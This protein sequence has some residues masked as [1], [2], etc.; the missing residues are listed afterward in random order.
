ML[1]SGGEATQVVIRGL[2][3][4]FSVITI[5]G[6]PIPS[7][8]GVH[9]NEGVDP[10][11]HAPGGKEGGNTES[12]GR[13]TDIGMVSSNMLS[14]IEVYKTVTPDMDAAAIGGTVNLGIRKAQ[15][16]PSEILPFA[17]HM[18]NITFLAQG[19]YKDILKSYNP[20][21]FDLTLERRLFNNKFGV[22]M[23]GIAQQQ[24]LTSNSL[25]ARY[26]QID[27][28]TDPDNLRLEGMDL[29]F[30]PRMEKRYN[31]SV[32]LDYVLPEG[33][34]ALL[35]IFSKS[36]RNTQY[37]Q[38]HYGLE[39]GGNQIDYYAS[40]M[41]NNINLITNILSY[42]QR[43][44]SFD[45][46]ARLSHSYSENISP[47][48]WRMQFAQF[49]AGTFAI[50]EQLPPVEIA[51]EAF[52]LVNLDTMR[53][54]NVRTSNSLTSQRNMR[55]SLDLSRD[56]NIADFLSFNLKAGGMYGYTDRS[57]DYDEGDGFV[58]F[59]T[60]G[61]SILNRL[62]WLA[63][64]GTTPTNNYVHIT[65]FL[66]PDY[67]IGTYLE[68]DYS[69]DNSLYMDD[70]SIIKDVVVDYGESLETAPT[71][72]AGTWVP[73]VLGN[74]RS[75]YSGYEYRSAGYF[76]GTFN[77]GNLVTVIAGARY[78]NLTTK[79]RANRYYNCTAANP[80]PNELPHI[81]TTIT[82][83]HGY[84]LPDVLVRLKPLSWLGLR[85][86]YTNTISYPGFNE[87]IPIIGVYENSVNWNNTD[88]KPALSG[89]FDAQLSIHQN[90][91]GLFAIGGF[92]KR[93]NDF[94][95]SQS[96]FII[97]P[98]DYPG[99]QYR[100]L[101]V[102]GYHINTYYNNPKRVDVYGVEAEWQTHFWY[103][104]K[105]L[106]GL[107]LN[108]N[109]THILS[110]ATYPFSVVS[111]G[112]FPLYQPVYIDSTYEDRLIDQPDD[113]INLSLGYDY[114]DFSILVSMIY[115]S[116]IF[117]QTDFWNALR[118]DKAEYLRWDLVAN[119]KLPWYN[120]EVFL[121]LNNLNGEPDTYIIRGNGYPQ[122]KYYYGLTVDLGIR[123]KL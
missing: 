100:E 64:Y 66:D 11:L 72:G 2:Q 89:N 67:N 120:S 36:E 117:N 58:R 3:P 49:A 52:Q 76:M 13:G 14:S 19:G 6:V 80:Y 81:D 30:Y 86:A 28:A 4:R 22:L 51:S 93:I 111:P 94:V 73:S 113:I 87:I 39:N 68:N 122:S 98:A 96:G 10:W 107:V 35:N 90:Y 59:G 119:Q 112:V 101:D 102:S 45:V 31:G 118:V 23:Q 44:F 60:I 110:E 25:R 106:N 47:D 61:Q 82:K 95:F 70:L 77:F 53:L 37:F 41:P 33:N 105:P 74:G 109:F 63:D 34:I 69:F 78:Q 62:P 92:L 108:V 42:N 115:Q 116:G 40:N 50:N 91:I 75:D 5:D 21:K 99:L 123:L 79:Y 27:K 57:Y 29:F 55:A 56:F 15:Y 8:V 114:K 85:V 84:W 17:S 97:D 46:D 12:G 71:G 9:S 7:N 83:T 103:L 65:P 20:Y 104:P 38:Q 121:H 88:L 18:P 1:R 48:N 24:N 43:L 26:D 54:N 32:T 16:R